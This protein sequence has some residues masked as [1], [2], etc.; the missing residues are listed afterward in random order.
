MQ[1]LH[2]RHARFSRRPVDGRRDER[3]EIVDVHN[4]RPSCRH[5]SVDAFFP[6]QRINTAGRSSGAA[7]KAVDAGVL[8]LEQRYRVPVRLEQVFL[9]LHGNIFAAGLLVAVMEKKDFHWPVSWRMGDGPIS[10]FP[11][12]GISR[13]APLRSRTSFGFQVGGILKLKL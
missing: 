10:M 3:K 4:V 7:P 2:Q 1:R 13:W 11:L 8:R 5:L 6:G 9:G 12:G